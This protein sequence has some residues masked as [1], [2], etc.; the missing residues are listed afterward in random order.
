VATRPSE[1]PLSCICRI[2]RARETALKVGRTWRHISS[3]VGRKSI[4]RALH[5]YATSRFGHRLVGTVSRD[6]GL[7]S[8]VTH[9]QR[10][11]SATSAKLPSSFVPASL[12]SAILISERGDRYGRT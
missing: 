5:I 12:Q 4:E 11:I 2:R 3:L 10:S 1:R 9:E 8:H 6:R 7:S